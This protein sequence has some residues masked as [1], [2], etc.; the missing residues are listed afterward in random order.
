MAISSV[1]ALEVK[2]PDLPTRVDEGK[3]IEFEITISDFKYADK[4]IITTS[5][6]KIKGSPLF[7]V[8]D[9][10]KGFDK[11]TAEISVP[12]NINKLK[13]KVKGRAPAGTL[14]VR[15]DGLEITRFREGELMY[16]QVTLYREG[17]EEP[18]T[19]P[20]LKTF[21]L[22]I[23]K[24]EEFAQALQSVPEE[25]QS[26]KQVAQELFDKGLVREAFELV[27][28]LKQSKAAQIPLWVKIIPLAAAIVAFIALIAGYWLGSNSQK[29]L[30]YRPYRR[31]RRR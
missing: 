22:N 31:Y 8:V 20:A 23:K 4:V 1:N 18:L 15:R 30:P 9:L 12:E 14:T 7:Y 19:S 16:Y 11:Q 24:K 25:F 3:T 2:S 5:L 28:A 13:V 17:E 10:D 21:R 26:A 29:W 6:E 27:D